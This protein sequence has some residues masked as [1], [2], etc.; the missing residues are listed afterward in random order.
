[1]SNPFDEI[2]VLYCKRC[3]SL[4]IKEDEVMGDYCAKCGTTDI[5]ETDIHTW[6]EL[7]KKKE[8]LKHINNLNYGKGRKK[9]NER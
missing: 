8:E 5:A 7:N 1:M 2:P 6:E 4:L 3:L 9:E